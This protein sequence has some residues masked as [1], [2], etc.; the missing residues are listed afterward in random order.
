MKYNYLLFDLDGTLTDPEE[1]I[2]K[3]V[4]YALADQGI[5]VTD[6]K[7]LLPFIGPPLDDSFCKFYGMDHQHAWQAIEKYRERFGTIGLFENRVFD[8]IPEMLAGLQ[9]EGRHLAVATSK[10]QVYTDRI[11]EKYQLSGYFEVIVG[12]EL[13]GSRKRKADII[14]E[15]WRQLGKPDKKQM[16]MIGDRH[17]D[18]DGAKAC[19]MDGAG[20]TFGYAPPGELEACGPVFLAHSVAELEELLRKA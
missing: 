10:P 13:D 3:C 11:L 2:T 1:G 12:S 18:L 7:E 5:T 4:Q 16:L 15:A 20:V 9:Q 17:H 14:E 6:R 8:G 19:G